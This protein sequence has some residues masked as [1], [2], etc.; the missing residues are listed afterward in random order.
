MASLRKYQ[1]NSTNCTFNEEDGLDKEAA[2]TF[3]P[4]TNPAC[5]SGSKVGAKAKED[6]SMQGAIG[7][8]GREEADELYC[9]V[10]IG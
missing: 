8:S 7:R 10:P 4:E 6:R 3:D 5:N 1:V 2:S 9:T